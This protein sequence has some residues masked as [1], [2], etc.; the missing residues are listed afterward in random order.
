MDDHAC[1]SAQLENHFLLSGILLDLPAHRRAAREADHLDA[2]VSHQQARVFVRK[3]DHVERAVGPARL[4]NDLRHENGRKWGL[5]CGLQDH[6]AA[7]RDCRRYFVRHQI[8]R[9]IKRSNAHD[10]AQ[11]KT[12]HNAPPSGGVFL[13]VQR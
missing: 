3:R 8:Q 2:I 9:K 6:G 12:L 1:I 10:R 7:R 13:P 4:L 11:R 5:R